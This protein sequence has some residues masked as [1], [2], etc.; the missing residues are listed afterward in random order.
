MLGDSC[1]RQRGR[2]PLDEIR[3]ALTREC[4]CAHSHCGTCV[5]AR[6]QSGTTRSQSVP[7]RFGDPEPST[8]PRSRSA[9]RED[10]HEDLLWYNGLRRR[11]IDAFVKGGGPQS[12]VCSCTSGTYKELDESRRQIRVLELQPGSDDEPIS[13][14]LITVDL[15]VLLPLDFDELVSIHELVVT[16]TKIIRAACSGTWVLEDDVNRW[17]CIQESLV[18][19]LQNRLLASYRTLKDAHG[20]PEVE[21]VRLLRAMRFLGPAVVL[22]DMTTKL[23]TA[24]LQ[25]NVHHIWTRRLNGLVY[26]LSGWGTRRRFSFFHF[27][28]QMDTAVDRFI[29]EDGDGMSALVPVDVLG[30]QRFLK[31]GEQGLRPV[32]SAVSWFW[33]DTKPGGRIKVDGKS[34][35]VPLNA[36][37]ALRNLR[38]SVDWKPL[39]IDAVCI[40]QDDQA[41]RAS[42]ILLMSDIY[43]LAESTYVWLG[44]W[45][46]AVSSAMATLEFILQTCQEATV[47][48]QQIVDEVEA[49]SFV[50]GK[51]PASIFVPMAHESPSNMSGFRALVTEWLESSATSLKEAIRGFP[52][53]HRLTQAQWQQLIMPNMSEDMC[54]L[55]DLPWF[56][57]LWVLQEVV[58]SRRCAV[59][60]EFRRYLL[61]DDLKKGALILAQSRLVPR[62]TG[63]TLTLAVAM[64]RDR[65]KNGYRLLELVAQNVNQECSDPRDHIF[66]LLGLTVWAKSGSK[67]PHLIRPN[68]EKSVSDCMRDATRVM[69]QQEGNLNALLFWCPVQQSPTWAIHWHRHKHIQQRATLHRL[70]EASKPYSPDPRPLNFDLMNKCPDLSILLLN[71]HSV[72]F[73]YSTRP[74]RGVGET[75]MPAQPFLARVAAVIQIITYM[76][77]EHE[78]S[79]RLIALTLMACGHAHQPSLSE[80]EE[81]RRLEYEVS[82]CWDELQGQTPEHYSDLST[83]ELYILATF[84]GL[85]SNGSAFTTSAG[86]LCIGPA[87]VQKGDKIVRL[88]GLD[89]PA[90]LHP[91]QSWFTFA[92]LAYI[93]L[94]FQDAQDT[95]TLAPEIFEIR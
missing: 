12:R 34:L 5:C 49:G 84:H 1:D 79:P 11:Q 42:Q 43:S 46:P 9:R 71:G 54:A 19:L 20:A 23:T 4:V 10:V 91:E 68:Y 81:F 8:T 72:S 18:R 83:G 57:R 80:M 31:E 73:V 77:T 37:N 47:S 33:G 29:S 65:S 94:E 39:W 62:P 48:P 32:F 59:V 61:W 74:I 25:R 53:G 28:N 38:D 66:G 88:F 16:G 35:E 78:F 50:R 36:I 76:S 52:A 86:Q 90:I 2:P 56:S 45:T 69:L 27:A 55:F 95:S 93:D 85:F 44:T 3:L 15:P 82:N 21:T 63:L 17:E 30:L 92:G 41:E 60:F 51:R 87:G 70:V 64:Y 40:N 13:G 26:R 75:E 22:H 58:L 89:L 24:L 7:R 67:W 14:N 6:F